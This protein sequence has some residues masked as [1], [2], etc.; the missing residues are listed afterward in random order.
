MQVVML[1]VLLATGGYTKGMRVMAS[2]LQMDSSWQ[3]CVVVSGPGAN[4]YYQLNCAKDPSR[5]RSLRSVPGKWMRPAGRAAV[6]GS[7]GGSV[8]GAGGSVGGVATKPKESA[9]PAK[10]GAVATGAYECWAFN[11]ARSNLNFTVT[12]PGS[13]RAADGSSGGF[14]FDPG[15]GR[16]TFTG[17]L[18]DVL[19]E[20]FTTVYH[21]PK[22]HPTVSFRRRGAEASFCERV[23]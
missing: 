4:D 16:I 11:T 9:A 1:A 2:P 15:S 19:P 10:T 23:G 14:T 22:G 17:Y 21:E 18:A 5:E 3:E 12:G 20:G 6:H 13:Y 8:S 7:I